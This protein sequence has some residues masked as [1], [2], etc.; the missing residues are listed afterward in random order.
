MATRAQIEAN[1]N[2]ARRSTGPKDTSLSRFNGL[3]HGYPRRR[4]RA[5]RARTPPRSRPRFD[6][7]AR[8]PAADDP[9]PAV[10]VDLAAVATWRL[11]RSIRAGSAVRA[12]LADD[13][14]RAFDSKGHAAVEPRHRP[15]R[16]RPQRRPLPAR[17]HRPGDRPPAHL[18]GRAGRLPRGRAG[19]LGPAVPPAADDPVGPPP[20]HPLFTAGAGAHR[21]GA[22]AAG[23]RKLRAAAAQGGGG[24]DG[25]GPAADGGRGG[26]RGSGSGARTPP[27]RLRPVAGPWRRPRRTRRTSF[28]WC[29]VTRWDP[30][31]VA[32]LEAAA[33]DGPW[34]SPAPTSATSPNP[35]PRPRRK[36]RPG[37]SRRI[38]RTQQ[39]VYQRLAT[40]WL[41]S[42]RR[43][44]R[45]TVG[46]V[47][48]GL[49]GVPAGR[50]GPIRGLE[51]PRTHAEIRRSG[52]IGRRPE[53]VVARG[54]R[55]R[56]GAGLIGWRWA[57]PSGSGRRWRARPRRGGRGTRPSAGRVADDR[58]RDLAR[59]T[60]V[61]VGRG[62]PG[63]F[64]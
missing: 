18:L 25:G 39:F 62:H 12:R 53:R 17:V 64:L 41:R 36:P 19:R 14:V 43:P 2:N 7:Q 55:G 9:T 3:K 35:S 54:A 47:R 6:G 34:R 30:R 13:A 21:L 61:R 32:P 37:R 48:R 58:L 27:T 42:G 49:R 10:L 4:G 45:G 28:G 31:A 57:R 60:G 59:A 24:G 15:L 5:A 38:N 22:S 56:V 16:G 11:R 8:R 1:R 63:R 44:R 29:I 20:R 50:P 26:A 51:R 46:S 33:V 23:A 40:N 52:W